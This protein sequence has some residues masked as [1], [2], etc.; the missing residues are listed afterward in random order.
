MIRLINELV[1]LLTELR[2]FLSCENDRRMVIHRMNVEVASRQNEYA[3]RLEADLKRLS[4]V[5]QQIHSGAVFGQG[6]A[7]G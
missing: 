5:R 6:A 7:D 4:E 1:G 2:A 3:A